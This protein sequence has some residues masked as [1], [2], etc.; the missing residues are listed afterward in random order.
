MPEKLRGFRD[1]YPEDQEIRREIFETMMEECRRFGFREVDGPSI[2]SVD[3]YAHKSGEE[4]MGQMF[5]FID[6]GGR[7]VTLVPEFT[8]TLARMV[9]SRK[10]L[11]KPLKWYTLAI[12][13]I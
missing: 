4:I 2:E 1:F 9:A 6:K 5:N 13:E 8:P 10:D 11:I 7:E 3:L 12:L